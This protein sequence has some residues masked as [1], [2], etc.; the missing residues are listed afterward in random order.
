MQPLPFSVAELERVLSPLEPCGLPR[1]AYT[2]EVVF[3]LEREHIFGRAWSCVG[4]EQELVR[5]GDFV[6]ARVA[7]EELL[8]VRGVDLELRAFHNVC[9]HRG[10]LLVEP[11][12]GRSLE[13]TC[14]Y[15]GWSYEP[16]GAL[17]VAPYM[18]PSF[19]REC[20]GLTS[21]RLEV[22]H[23]FVFVCLD[24][25]AQPLA[26]AL[27]GAPEWL[28]KPELGHLR[29][30]RSQ[31]H[32]VAANWKLLVENFQESHHFQSVH[33]A[34]EQQTP[35]ASATS[36][37]CAGAWLGGLM[38][39]SPWLR[40]VALPSTRERPFIVPEAERGRVADALA[41]P[42][43]LTSLQPDYLLTYHLEP[44]SATRTRVTANTYFHAAAFAPELQAEDVFAFWDRVNREDRQICER[45]QLGLASRSFERA[46]YSLLE[47]G[48]H[49][50]DQWVARR[51]L[52]L[53]R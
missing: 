28:T 18:P 2:D 30:G 21:V 38:E 48:T 34:L 33:P 17:R 10:L 11:E 13:L 53:T 36:W 43:L 31:S 29:L 40:T 19:R 24:P 6:R 25:R 49:A 23:G 46:S 22:L 52:E 15:H 32:E 9:R 20:H 12:R 14:G 47:E 39:L 42:A 16:S 7:G 1:A 5:P 3:A 50:F 37:A 35:S 27:D 8:V 41:M 26:E 4:R 44:L 45:Q 51:Y